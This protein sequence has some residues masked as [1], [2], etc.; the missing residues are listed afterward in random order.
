[1]RDYRTNDVNCCKNIGVPKE[2]P[3]P[4]ASPALCKKSLEIVERKKNPPAPKPKVGNAL[5]LAVMKWIGKE[6]C[7]VIFAAC[8]RINSMKF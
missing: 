6:M 2:E 8:C 1:M 3:A 4:A 5:N 7:F